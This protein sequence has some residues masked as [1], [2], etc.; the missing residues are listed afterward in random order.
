MLQCFN[1]HDPS[2]DTERYVIMASLGLAEC[3]NHHDP[4]EDTERILRTNRIPSRNCFNHH[5]P[6]EDTERTVLHIHAAFADEVSTTTIRPRILKV[7]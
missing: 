7:K 1:H 3:F 5:D 4:S 2:E 6:S